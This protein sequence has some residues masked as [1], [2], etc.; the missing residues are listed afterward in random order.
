MRTEVARIEDQ[1]APARGGA[2]LI[3]IPGDDNVVRAHRLRLVCFVRASDQGDDLCAHRPCELDR[4]LTDCAV[5]TIPIV[6]LGPVPRCL[7]TENV[8]TSAEIRA[9]PRPD[10]GRQ[11]TSR[12]TA[13]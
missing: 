2:Y 7:S 5:P 11:R 12:G 1:V 10:P 4:D 8:G 13:R 3:R 9:L 6:I